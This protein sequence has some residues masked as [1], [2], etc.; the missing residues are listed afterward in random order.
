MQYTEANNECP[1]IAFSSPQL[2]A[3]SSP[4]SA[5]TQTSLT[6]SYPES[7]SEARQ[8]GRG[9][10]RC[11]LHSRLVYYLNRR[12]TQ[13]RP[14]PFLPFPSCLR[15]RF[16]YGNRGGGGDVSN[17]SRRKF[18]FKP[19]FSSSASSASF[20]DPKKTWFPISLQ[21]SLLPPSLLLLLLL[22]FPSFLR[23]EFLK[24]GAKIGM[25][26]PG[27]KLEKVTSHSL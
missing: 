24:D 21:L 3:L 6:V 22:P 27:G 23:N 25:N 19:Y 13:N 5:C 1:L 4:M 15:C 10:K 12:H 18:K 20:V 7:H 9:V 14:Q 17:E 26:G 8:F 11:P 2:R 16:L